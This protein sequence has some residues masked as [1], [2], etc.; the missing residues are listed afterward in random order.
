MADYTSTRVIVSNM[1]T[2]E[3]SALK[4]VLIEKDVSFETY[5]LSKCENLSERKQSW[6]LTRGSNA[7]RFTL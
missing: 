7:P 6:L 2:T 4:K 3:N 1:V 5:H